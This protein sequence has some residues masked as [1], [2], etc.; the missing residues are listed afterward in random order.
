MAGVKLQPD[1]VGCFNTD[2]L[3]SVEIGAG[4]KSPVGWPSLPM[5]S[6]FRRPEKL[7]N[8]YVVQYHFCHI[9]L[10]K[11]GIVNK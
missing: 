2:S 10:I 8:S 1:V 9:L 3:A 7:Q 6:E 5:E 4:C 11:S